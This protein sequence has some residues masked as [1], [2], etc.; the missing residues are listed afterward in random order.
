MNTNALR[1]VKAAGIHYEVREYEVDEN[2]LGAESAASK[3]GLDIGRVFKTLVAV[4]DRTGP[5]VFVIPGNLELNLKKAAL[6]S[7]D[8]TVSMLPL[9]ELQNLTGY[10]R[11]GCSPIGLKKK[12]PVFVDET[13]VLWDFVSVSAGARGIQMLLAPADLLALC[14]GKYADLA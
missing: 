6:A 8:K 3:I 5:L 4:G 10:Q 13:A 11:G 9:K 12:L 14:E 2:D 7:A 1:L